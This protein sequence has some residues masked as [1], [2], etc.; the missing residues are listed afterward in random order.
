MGI[1]LMDEYHLHEGLAQEVWL[2][3]QQ[4][5]QAGEFQRLHQDKAR[6]VR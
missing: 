6:L 5:I 4:R 2:T 1:P 3:V